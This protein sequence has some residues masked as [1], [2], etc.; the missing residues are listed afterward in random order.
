VRARNLKPSIFRNELLAVADPLYTL[1]FQGLWC[2]ADRAGRLE[3]RPAKIHLEINPGRAYERTVDALAW[4]TDQ[5][6]IQ[7]YEAAG[8][9]YILVI[10]FA[11]HQSPHVK[12]PNSTLPAPDGNG[13]DTRPAP[14]QHHTRTSAAALTPD[15]GL[16]TA[17]S[18]LLTP[19][20]QYQSSVA[21]PRARE[22][23]KSD[24]FKKTASDPKPKRN[25]SSSRG[26]VP[27]GEALAGLPAKP[28]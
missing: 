9:R 20:S 17:D 12:E 26:L 6:F 15:S 11:K 27:I 23:P 14:D 24:G 7:R 16:R 10:N 2:L 21:R 1:I 13:A 3:D 18:G 22:T 8:A 4:L 5:G 25:P 28:P 19:D